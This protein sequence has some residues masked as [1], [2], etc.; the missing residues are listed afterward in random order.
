MLKS[1][2]LIVLTQLLAVFGVCCFWGCQKCEDMD[3]NGVCYDWITPPTGQLLETYHKMEPAS[4][5]KNQVDDS[6][7]IYQDFSD[8]FQEAWKDANSMEFYKVFAGALVKNST[9]FYVVGERSMDRIEGMSLTAL[10]ARVTNPKNYN[11]NYAA[12]DSALNKIVA[13][14]KRAVFVTDGELFTKNSGESELPWARNGFAQWLKAG[15]KLSFFVTDFVEKKKNKHVFYMIFTPASEVGSATEVAA[16]LEY[17]LKNSPGLKYDVFHFQNNAFALKTGFDGKNPGSFDMDL[18]VADYAFNAKNSWEYAA[19]D[20]GWADIHKYFVDNAYDDNDKP[21]EGGRPLI[22]N[23]AS[24]GRPAYFTLDASQMEFYT[25]K[26]V[27]L[28]VYSIYDDFYLY[29]KSVKC[30]N[31]PREMKKSANGEVEIDPSTEM[32]IVLS[33][34]E[35][36]CYNLDDGTLLPMYNY[37][38]KPVKKLTDVLVLNKKHFFDT[39]SHNA[40]GEIEIQ[41]APN[42]DGKSL[43]DE[44]ANLLKLELVIDSI[45]PDSNLNTNEHLNVFKWEGQKLAQNNAM[46]HSVVHALRDAVPQ[47]QVLFT[48]YVRTPANDF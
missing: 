6:L 15:N 8:G 21:I 37:S 24:G 47:S 14:K 43:S 36:G 26:S 39:M 23:R 18:A 12:L 31:N 46:Y 13:E 32:P 17:A 41:V 19:I 2:A 28:N 16:T 22:G 40:K 3:E 29:A 20:L 11:R 44:H 30:K 35:P 25:V 38:P 45:S 4:E 5:Q 9:K 10:F 1:R 34:G 48:W 27:S 42:F 7:A 33:E